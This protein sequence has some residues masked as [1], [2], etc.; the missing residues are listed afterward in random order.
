MR[1]LFVLPVAALMALSFASLGLAQTQPAEKPAAPQTMPAEKKAA[2]AEKP[3]AKPRAKI[4]RGEVISVDP[5][6]QTL[7]VKA[8]DKELSFTV[9]EKAAK[10]LA[11]LKA[12]DRVIVGYGEVD[13]K[14]IAK[15]IRKAKAAKKS[16]TE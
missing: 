3:A 10:A 5:E 16:A 2:P 15:A 6:A 1:K 13:G 8:K 4:A 12:G 7:V 14:L 11:N 9:E